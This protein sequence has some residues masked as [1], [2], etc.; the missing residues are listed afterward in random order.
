[1]IQLFFQVECSIAFLSQGC[2]H[3]RVKFRHE[4]LT[5]GQEN[6]F[7]WLKIPLLDAPI[8]VAD[9][10]TS[11]EIQPVLTQQNLLEMSAGLLKNSWFCH[12]KKGWRYQQV[13]LQIS[14]D[15]TRTEVGHLAALLAVLEVPNQFGQVQARVLDCNSPKVIICHTIYLNCFILF[16]FES[17]NGR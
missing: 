4:N 11:R 9:D 16:N 8:T 17:G 6:V 13:S 2:A 12:N 7:V 10:A 14:S 15:M 5:Q 1:M 3:A